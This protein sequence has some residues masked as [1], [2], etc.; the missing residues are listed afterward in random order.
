MP[1]HAIYTIGYGKRSLEEFLSVL[2]K[3]KI[4]YLIDV[5]SNPYSKYKPEFSKKP[6]QQSLEETGIRYVF[7]GDLLGGTPDDPACYTEGKADYDKIAVTEYF[8]RGIT[9]L[10]SAHE[11]QL[12]ICLM[13]GEGKPEICHRSKLIGKILQEK[14]IPVFHITES[15]D[16][17][18]QDYIMN[19]VNGW[20]M[21]L[22]DIPMTSR[23]THSPLE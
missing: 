2:G 22:F 4:S 12:V 8:Q 3:Y 18:S 5:R 16:M 10:C 9:R 14:E 17:K 1:D 15:D 11:Q 6:L 23:K 7:M 13:C 20:Q 19:V 21:M